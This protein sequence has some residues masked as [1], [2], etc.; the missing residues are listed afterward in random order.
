MNTQNSDYKIDDVVQIIEPEKKNFRKG[1]HSEGK[2][3]IIKCT[4]KHMGS[5]CAFGI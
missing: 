4:L 1:L 2:C 5:A 3:V